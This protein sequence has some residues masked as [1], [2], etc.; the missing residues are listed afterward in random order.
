MPKG[1]Q[2]SYDDIYNAERMAK[3]Q[4]EALV[5][6]QREEAKRREREEARR[7]RPPAQEPKKRPSYPQTPVSEYTRARWDREARARQDEWVAKLR[8]ENALA[9]VF[10]SKEYIR[11]RY[12]L[13]TWAKRVKEYQEKFR[14]SEAEAEEL[15]ARDYKESEWKHLE[16]PAIERFMGHR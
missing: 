3:I 10:G 8:A 15:L 4:A 16:V 7:Y 11:N 9:A 13:L 5:E 1:V 12:G 14:C 2:W 6:A